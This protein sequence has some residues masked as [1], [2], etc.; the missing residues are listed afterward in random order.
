M[1]I[2]LIFYP[3]L[4]LN[5][6]FKNFGPKEHEVTNVYA[7]LG[8]RMPNICF[9]GHVDVV[10]PVNEDLWSSDCFTMTIQDEFIYGRGAV[11]MKGAITCYLLAI[12]AFLKNNEPKGS[13]SFLIT[14]DEEGEAKHGTREMLEHIKD[15]TPKI[16]F[17]ILG[18]PTSKHNIGDTIKIGRRGSINFT[19][20]I[21]GKQGHVAFS[22]KAINPIPIITAVL[23]D[24]SDAQFNS[25]TEYFQP[26]NLEIA[27]IDTGN[28]VSN[29]IPEAVTA[30]FNIRF[31]D[32]Y[33]ANDLSSEVI[34]IISK[35][36]EAYDLKYTSS[37]ALF[38][39]NTPLIC[40]NLQK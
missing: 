30:K 7:I 34:N 25:G 17:C 16:D 32:T 1:S 13:I 31:N 24:L 33:S 3:S 20:K 40:K 27:S 37:S 36:S 21:T 28:P 22:E 10:P 8:N 18:K 26:S 14:S 35:H 19:L 9:A 11:D 5:A 39:K 38:F 15:Y 6:K 2:L 23:K 12:S 4:G 29:I